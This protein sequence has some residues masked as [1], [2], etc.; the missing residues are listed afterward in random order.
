MVVLTDESRKLSRYDSFVCVDFS[1]NESL[2][3]V[4]GFE[5]KSLGNFIRMGVD[6]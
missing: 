6:F 3:N 2:A 5:Q 4:K 1:I